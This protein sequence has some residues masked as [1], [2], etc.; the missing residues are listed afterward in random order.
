MKLSFPI[1]TFNAHMYFFARSEKLLHENRG[2]ARHFYL[3]E[4]LEGPVLQQEELSMVFVFHK[5]CNL[6]A[7]NNFNA[8]ARRHAEN[9]GGATRG[10]RQNLGGSAPPGTP[11]APPLHENK[12]KQ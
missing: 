6:I 2:G 4:P 3:G 1:S 5:F 11:L 7:L 12:Q 10:T 8:V 9:F